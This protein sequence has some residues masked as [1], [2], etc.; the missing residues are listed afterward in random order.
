MDIAG[1]LRPTAPAVVALALVA[2]AAPAAQASPGTGSPQHFSCA[3]GSSRTGVDLFYDVGNVQGTPTLTPTFFRWH[4]DNGSGGGFRMNALAIDIETTP[5]HY[6][7]MVLRGGSS[8]SLD[9][10][11]ADGQ[12]DAPLPVTAFHFSGQDSPALRVRCYGVGT[13]SVQNRV[14]DYA[15]IL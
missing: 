15:P 1:T 4:T 14:D 10:V 13:G 7:Q 2:L 12:W 9:D 6:T 11:G 3:S 8:T 5:D